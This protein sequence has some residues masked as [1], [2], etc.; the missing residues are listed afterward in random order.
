MDSLPNIIIVD[1][2]SLF[3]EGMK[4]LIEQEGLGQVVAEAENGQVFLELLEK[5]TPDLVL[6]DIEMPVMNGLEATKKARALLPDLKVLVVTMLGEKENYN[7]VINAGAM[8]FVLKTSGKQELERA[9]MTVIGG[10]SYFSNE[11]LRQIIKDFE[12]QQSVHTNNG[13]SDID[14]TERELEVLRYLCQG[15]TAAE[16]ARTLCRSIKTIEAHRSKLLEKT[17]TKNTINLILFALRN[18]LATL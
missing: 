15:L 17:N 18:K 10:E 2:H 12:K 16:I 1:D 8:G 3:R 5:I 4:L 6:M 9:I 11:L 13:A 7:E 14:F